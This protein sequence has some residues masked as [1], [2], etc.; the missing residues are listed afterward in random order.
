MTNSD[1]SCYGAWE[2]TRTSLLFWKHVRVLYFA[3]AFFKSHTHSVNLTFHKFHACFIPMSHACFVKLVCNLWN[4]L[5]IHKT[6]GEIQKRTCVFKFFFNT[7]MSP[8]RLCKL[9][10][11][12]EKKVSGE[13]GEVNV[14]MPCVCSCSCLV[15]SSVIKLE[16]P[17]IFCRSYSLHFFDVKNLRQRINISW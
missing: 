3:C 16:A 14:T 8:P 5:M 2:V 12:E 9:Q 4:V 1:V 11:V 10:M 13:R 6:C 7:S 17:D 15:N